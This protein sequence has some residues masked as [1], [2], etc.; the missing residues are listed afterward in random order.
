MLQ[1]FS[2]GK[3]AT[4]STGQE[5]GITSVHGSVFNFRRMSSV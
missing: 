3:L 2:N 4:E 5:I 1:N